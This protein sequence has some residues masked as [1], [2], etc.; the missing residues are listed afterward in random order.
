MEKDIEQYHAWGGGIARPI[1]PDMQGWTAGNV[2][3]TEVP[4]TPVPSWLRKILR[5]K[6]TLADIEKVPL[7]GR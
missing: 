2:V 5:S 6:K 1:W 7:L 3:M 4:G